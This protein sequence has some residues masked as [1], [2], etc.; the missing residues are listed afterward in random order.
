MEGGRE[1]GKERKERIGRKGPWNGII[2]KL[3]K[4]VSVAMAMPNEYDKRYTFF[5]LC[6]ATGLQPACAINAT[7]VTMT[8]CL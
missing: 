8:H 5:A 1:G 2:N 7:P 3:A 6:H 4:D